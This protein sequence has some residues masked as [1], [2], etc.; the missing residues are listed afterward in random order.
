MTWMERLRVRKIAW[1]QP[2]WVLESDILVKRTVS[3]KQ[4]DNGKCPLAV[5]KTL[6]LY[7]SSAGRYLMFNSTFDE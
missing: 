3:R 1:L 6:T 2:K 7:E 5:K 4:T